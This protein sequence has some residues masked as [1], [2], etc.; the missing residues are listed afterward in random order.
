MTKDNQSKIKA[1][2]LSRREFLKRVGLGTA[3]ISAAAVAGCT[4]DKAAS[5]VGQSVST[6]TDVPKGKMTYRTNPKTGEKVSLLGYGCMRWPTLPGSDKLDQDAINEL[7]DTAI[8]YGVNYFDTSPAYSQG[9]SEE[10]VGIA[11]SRHPRDKYFIATKLSNFD[12]STW[13]REASMKMYHDSFKKLRTDKIDYLLLHAIGLG[14]DGMAAL[15]GRYFDNGIL[16]FLLAEREAGRIGNLGFSYHGDIRAFDLLLAGHDKYRWDFVQIQ[17]NYLD[18]GHASERNP[19]E[20]NASYLYEECHKRGI[21][22]VI[23]EPL[24]GG[25]LSKVPD[26]IAARLKQRE[27]ERSVASWAFRYAGTPSGVLTVLSGMTY[28]EHLMD[29]LQT[30]C[31]L[32]PLTEGETE[33]LY[34]TANL[35]QEYPT[36]ACNDCKYCMPCPYGIDIPSIFVHYNKC[37]NE[38]NVPESSQAANYREARRAF[39]IGYDRSVPR[40]RQ[41]DHCI[42]CN[43]CSPHCPQ[44]IDIPSELKRVNDFVENLKQNKL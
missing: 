8:E 41:A 40:L 15:Q 42:G 31:P 10:A 6:H 39:L 43:Q 20:T 14:D 37:V 19:R 22:V 11:L 17:M 36:I 35:M 27:P 44:S 12:P 32:K 26:H 23:M 13:S 38:G 18:W 24:L 33:F 21:P 30:F 5:A 16:D 2:H 3:A 34:E 7:I 25:R 9:Q 1:A 4:P 29:N 28:K